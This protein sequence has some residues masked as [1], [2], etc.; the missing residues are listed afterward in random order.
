VNSYAHFFGN[1]PFDKYIKPTDSYTVALLAFGEGEK[2]EVYFNKKFN[3][4]KL[5]SKGWHNYHHVFPYDYKTSEHDKYWCNY[6]TGFLE[7]F[8]WLGEFPFTFQLI[9]LI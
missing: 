1:K 4:F 9:L 6:T 2:G 5:L 3:W 8:A 7:L